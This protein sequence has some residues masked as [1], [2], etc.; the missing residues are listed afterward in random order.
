MSHFKTLLVLWFG[1]L[2]TA[3]SSAGSQ[4]AATI[5]GWLEKDVYFHPPDQIIDDFTV[6]KLDM[7]PM[8]WH[9]TRKEGMWKYWYDL[10]LQANI[11]SC[12]GSDAIPVI[13]KGLSNADFYVRIIA[14]IALDKM[15]GLKHSQELRVQGSYVDLETMKQKRDPIDT[16]F[17][18]VYRDR[19]SKLYPGILTEQESADK[20]ATK[21][22][23]KVPTTTQPSPPMSKDG[24]SAV[25]TAN[26]ESIVY[27]YAH[28]LSLTANDV[29]WLS[30][31]DVLMSSLLRRINPDQ[32]ITLATDKV[33]E[34]YKR[35]LYSLECQ[36]VFF[37]GRMS[38]KDIELYQVKVF[39][40]ISDEGSGPP[41]CESVFVR[42]DG[43]LMFQRRE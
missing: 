14:A 22:A 21:P 38:G 15:L 42:S 24:P 11:L 6:P 26:M 36:V 17:I 19:V 40:Y 18:Q 12:T 37:R 4:Q 1:L 34:L 29:Q 43:Q 25:E 3:V 20:P 10:D 32:A 8:V 28:W 13:I 41:L 23:D 16:A 33:A 27:A 5:I 2:T 31:G 30:K 35:K 39:F 9:P 7:G